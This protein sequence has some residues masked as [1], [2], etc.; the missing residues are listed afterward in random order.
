[1]R[2]ISLEL[3]VNPLDVETFLS[4]SSVK[5]RVH[6]RGTFSSAAN[7]S[8]YIAAS[9]YYRTWGCG[10]KAD[11]LL[12]DANALNVE[13]TPVT[14]RPAT[15]RRLSASGSGSFINPHSMLI[16]KDYM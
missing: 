8:Y 16:A 9:A 5:R 2:G 15:P 11:K 12:K 1:M 14:S 13:L 7:F 3:S 4:G 10:Y 6:T